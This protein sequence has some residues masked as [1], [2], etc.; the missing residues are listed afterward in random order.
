MSHRKRIIAVGSVA[1]AS[2]AVTGLTVAKPGV[3][4]H[5]LDQGSKVIG[6]QVQ[7][8]PSIADAFRLADGRKVT[9][10]N[11]LRRASAMVNPDPIRIA[12][13]NLAGGNP[14]YDKVSDE[15]ALADPVLAEVVAGAPNAA[16]WGGQEV[17][18]SLA[19]KLEA[20]SAR[21]QNFKVVDLSL[22]SEHDDLLVPKRYELTDSYSCYFTGSQVR[23]GIDA[24]E[25]AK[26]HR[27]SIHRNAW[28]QFVAPRGY[29]VARVLDPQTGES[30][31]VVNTH[32]SYQGELRADTAGQLTAERRA[33]AARGDAFVVT[34]DANTLMRGQSKD[35]ERGPADAKVRAV[36]APSVDFAPT[37][38]A[39]HHPA[40]DLIAGPA[41]YQV[42]SSERL[43][44]VN[45]EDALRTSDHA[46][47][48]VAVL[49]PAP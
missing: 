39:R 23:G 22:G 30:L 11:Q 31:T 21:T 13:H 18:P 6:T 16:L 48:V 8:C 7:H 5:V 9:L 19:I 17:R 32:L 26:E 34:A 25:A 47:L 33:A 46:E 10:S 49:P 45:G 1:A 37:L 40:I 12:T 3:V 41:D 4:A 38:D 24:A 15:Q 44:V 28:T 43:D 2:V 36:L 27:H 20:L 35:P 42:V 14:A 29:N